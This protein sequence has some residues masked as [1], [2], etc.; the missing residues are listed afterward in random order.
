MTEAISK[1]EIDLE[2][3]LSTIDFYSQVLSLEQLFSYG[4]RHFHEI[5]GLSRSAL[6]TLEEGVYVLKDAI[7]Y[8]VKNDFYPQSSL[9]NKIATLCGRI[10]CENKDQYFKKEF[11][12]KYNAEIII[13]L[14]VKDALIGF[15]VT[16]KTYNKDIQHQDLSYLEGIKS[17]F[18]MSL[19]NAIDRENYEGLKTDL[20]KKIYNLMLVNQCTRLIMAERNLD[21]LYSLCIDVVRELTA[22]SVTTFGLYDDLKKSIVV[23][24]HVDILNPGR[25]IIK[26]FKMKENKLKPGKT[27]FHLKRDRD[28]LMDILENVDALDYI[29]AEYIVFI[30]QNEILGFVTVGKPVNGHFYDSITLNQIE[31]ISKSIYISM[32]NAIY[33]NEINTGKEKIEAQIKGMKKLSLMIKNIN[34]CNSIEEICDITLETL[35]L[36]YKCY[37]GFIIIKNKENN[38]IKTLGYKKDSEI[39]FLERF[40][41]NEESIH[42]SHGSSDI[43]T[44]FDI[45]DYNGDENCLIIC[46]VKLNDFSIYGENIFGHIVITGI[47]DS[48][49]EKNMLIVETISNSIA[50]IIGHIKERE[51]AKED[52]IRDERRIFHKAVSD[53]A[54]MKIQYEID[55]KVYYK[56]LNRVPFSNIDFRNYRYENM[57]CYDNVILVIDDGCEDINEIDFDGFVYGDTGCEVEANIINKIL[58]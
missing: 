33:I 17:L 11:L 32:K 20:D 16:E 23:K 30:A 43:S 53:F 25:K 56:I 34:S 7:G 52:M 1:R 19:S 4:Y 39:K 12:L 40:D 22:S 9:T 58:I 6:F 5:T 41:L 27:I 2:C 55:F 35:R 29:S 54:L 44:Y 46:P 51:R 45:S 14:I 24:G 37:R 49:D 8:E 57:F 28:V 48:V 18:N 50:P 3:I 38:I 10:L 31:S 26:E 15:I 36:G 21:N 47:K 42:Y 13:P